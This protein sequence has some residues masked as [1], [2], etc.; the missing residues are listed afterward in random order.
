MQ[1]RKRVTKKLLISN[2]KNIKDKVIYK[3]SW[4]GNEA[5]RDK[6]E[7]VTLAYKQASL[8]LKKECGDENLIHNTI[9]TMNGNIHKLKGVNSA[10]DSI[11]VARKFTS[12]LNY[13][14]ILIEKYNICAYL[15]HKTKD[16]LLK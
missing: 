1:E 5:L 11:L 2:Y 14:T 10:D 6:L 12:M 16:D 15:V 7:R 8:N 4:E 13:S 9:A 3:K